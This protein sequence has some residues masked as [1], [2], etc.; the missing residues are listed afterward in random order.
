MRK[1]LLFTLLLIAV[2]SSDAAAQ[3]CPLVLHAPTTVYWYSENEAYV[4]GTT[5][6]DPWWTQWTITN[7]VI[8]YTSPDR[9]RIRFQTSNTGPVSISANNYCT[10]AQWVEN[11]QRPY[12]C[13]VTVDRPKL[14]ATALATTQTINVTAGCA[15]ELHGLPDWI[16]APNG[17]TGNG[18]GTITLQFASNPSSV[19]RA[20]Y[21]TL[22]DK[23][24]P[25]AQQGTHFHG[26]DFNNDGKSD[27]LW[28]NTSNGM[29][30]VSFGDGSTTNQGRLLS[31][32]PNQNWRITTVADADGDNYTDLLW[33]N[34]AS[35][36]LFLQYV[37]PSG[38]VAGPGGGQS[39][40]R[41]VGSG[42]VIRH[43]GTAFDF[44]MQRVDGMGT[45]YWLHLDGSEYRYLNPSHAP[46]WTEKDA[47]WK[48]VSVDDFD[49]NGNADILYRNAVTGTCFIILTRPDWW[50]V[51]GSGVYHYEADLAWQIADTADLNGD[52]MAD[53]IWRNTDGRVWVQLMNGHTPI[54]SGLIWHEADPNWVIKGSGD[55]NGDGN[56]DLLWRNASTGI[57]FVMLMDGT[58]I[59]STSIMH[60]EP[61]LSWKLVAPSTSAAT[62]DGNPNP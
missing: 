36:G 33:R 7:A 44:L 60:R 3:D 1:I 13:A 45:L 22:N 24:L 40:A 49:G 41:V 51:M 19:P 2:G 42:P 15:W 20:L 9:K 47:N 23:I 16:T 17:T 50:Y 5:Y 28:R 11:Q 30:F 54:A 53:V 25:V 56:A 34:M 43:N 58:N 55:F 46:L 21:L 29:T 14:T 57:V 62:F 35:G 18:N 37:T 52:G 12:P 8:V 39:E 38:V 6:E 27:L 26:P 4:T 61:D 32:E 10:R 59:L 48:V 31:P